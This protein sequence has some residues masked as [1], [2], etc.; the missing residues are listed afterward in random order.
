M[1]PKSGFKLLKNDQ[2]DLEPFEKCKV[3]QRQWHRICANYSKKIFPEGFICE[4]CR[5]Q[6]SRLKPE[7]KFTAK[8]NFFLYFYTELLNFV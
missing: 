6:K 2:I 5:M 3:C 1:A 8:S 7:N 4:S